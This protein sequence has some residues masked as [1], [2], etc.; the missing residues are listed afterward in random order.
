M[1]WVWKDGGGKQPGKHNLGQV[2][3]V[4]V[5]VSHAESMSPWSDGLRM[6][7]E[8]RGLFLQEVKRQNPPI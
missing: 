3:Q 5:R 1:N 8:L 4:T 7:L 6:A 2:I